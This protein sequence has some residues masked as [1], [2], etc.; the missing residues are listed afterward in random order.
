M[1]RA[2]VLLGVW[3]LLGACRASGAESATVEVWLAREGRAQ[4]AVVIGEWASG[5]VRAAA[6][7]LA[8]YLGQMA[9]T[10]FAVK[11]GDGV[12]GLAVGVLTDFPA[13]ATGVAFDPVDPLRREQYRLRT[14]PRGVWLLG[15]TE[16]AVEHAVWD[17]LYRLGYRQFFPGEKWE[18]VPALPDLRLAV[19]CLGTPAYHARRIWYG[20]GPLSSRVEGYRQWSARNR[21]VQGFQLHSSHSY[22]AIIAANREAFEA[23]PEFY[24]L[25]DGQRRMTGGDIKFCISNPDL[26][27]LVVAHAVREMQA[28]PDRDSI[29]MDP[30]DG[31]NWC[32]CRPC[33]AMGSI[34]DRVLTL[35][36]EVAEAINTLDLGDRYVGIYAYAFHGPPPTIKVHPKV[37]VTATAGFLRGG[38]TLDQ[39][40]RGW[41]ARGAVMGVYDYFSVMPWDWDMPGQAR[42]S[43]PSYM[44]ETIP[45]FHGMNVRFH[46]AES[47]DNWGPNGL[48]YYVAARILWDLDEAERVDDII[49]DFLWR[50]FGPAREPLAEFYRL[51]DGGNRPLLSEN[52]VGRMYRSLAEGR[53]LAAADDGILGRIDDLILYTRYVE[54]KLQGDPLGALRHCHRIRDGGMVHFRAMWP[55]R[56]AH[57]VKLE[58]IPDAWLLENSYER[59]E[60]VAMLEAGIEANRPVDFMPVAFSRE[61]VPATPLNLPEVPTGSLGDLYQGHGRQGGFDLY[62]WLDEPGEIEL[63]VTGGLIAHYRDR[64]HVKIHLH[65]SQELTLEPVAYDESVP[66]DGRERTVTL[67]TPH[68]GLHRLDVQDGGDASRIFWQEDHP[69]TLPC[70]PESGGPPVNGAWTLYFYVPLGTREV[71]GYL[72]DASGRLLDGAGEEMLAFTEIKVPGYFNV[73]VPEGRDG[74]LWRVERSRAR[75]M[76]MTVPPYLARNEKELLLPREVVQ[77]DSGSP[78]H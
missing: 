43:R 14:H 18:V 8:G 3:L 10:E 15:A 52:L 73:P 50:A 27:K 64:G 44:A 61:L 68:A 72:N 36:N 60:I 40:I 4:Q 5:R 77:A 69:M 53:R 39:V 1:D 45:E 30:S 16:L 12:R 17:F 55:W 46:D 75:L 21:V 56:H 66:P 59:A 48:G 35:A 19:D 37:I 58:S 78:G 28:N 23:S 63:Q 49:D 24:A 71:A 7:E 25:V 74:Q 33:A 31:G 32:E 2:R 9:G 54:L 65:S 26:R 13:L 76:L 62:T 42:A 11:E 29:S 51:I 57:G 22:E 67:R 6:E 38:Y 47:S 70:S 20:H 41:Q 34:S